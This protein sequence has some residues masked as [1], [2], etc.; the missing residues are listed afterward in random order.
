MILSTE[1]RESQI[2]G[3]WDEYL[4]GGVT[5]S[6]FA[7]FMAYDAETAFINGADLSA[8]LAACATIETYL[9]TES[10]GDAKASFTFKELIDR[11]VFSNKLKDELETLRIYRNRWVHV[12]DPSDDGKLI[13][14]PHVISSQIAGYADLAMRCM[15]QSLCSNPWV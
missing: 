3:Y 1:I 4:K 2:H 15:I 8:I 13:S 6:E 14:H 9:R 11:S 5:T 12:R 7:I 10:I